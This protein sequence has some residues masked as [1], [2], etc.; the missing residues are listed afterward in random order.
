[1]TTGGSSNYRDPY[2]LSWALFLKLQ[3]DVDREQITFFEK[4]P[5]HFGVRL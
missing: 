5:T 3:V 4:C 2:K 1:M